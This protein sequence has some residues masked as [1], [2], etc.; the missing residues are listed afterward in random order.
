[1]SAEAA[2]VQGCDRA[3]GRSVRD[4]L[5]EKKQRQLDSQVG[6]NITQQC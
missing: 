5:K 1:M 4:P 2:V 6:P 3:A